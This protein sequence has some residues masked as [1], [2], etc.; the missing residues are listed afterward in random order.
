MKS[1]YDQF[2]SKA[3]SLDSSG[4]GARKKVSRSASAQRPSPIRKKTRRS[5]KKAQLPLGAVMGLFL[6]LSIAVTGLMY[7]DEIDS[8]LSIVEVDFGGKAYAAEAKKVEKAAEAKAEN[9]EKNSMSA[10]SKKSKKGKVGE[11][12]SEQEMSFLSKLRH[13]KD[14]LDQREESL[15]ELERELQKQKQEI[16][17]EIAR[18]DKMRKDI[19]GILKDK[20]QHDKERVGKLVEFYSNMK[21]QSAAKVFEDMNEDL[22]VEILG[23]MKKKNA[24]SIMNLL[25][26]DKA[27][28]LSEKFAG[29]HKP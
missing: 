26:T 7:I 5:N 27:Q 21:P 13:R 16:Q 20:I 19:A 2:F 15:N 6:G 23:S 24:A 12:W 14:E 9:E 11:A 25:K 10:K 8:F 28:V 22:A 4:E 29:Y 3:Q 17:G 1:G 18:L